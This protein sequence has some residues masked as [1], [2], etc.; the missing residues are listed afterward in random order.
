LSYAHLHLHTH[1]SLLDGANKIGDLMRRVA[2]LGMPAAAMT[3]H[4]NMFGTVEFYK[5]A[6]AHGVKPVIGC[7]VYV[8]PRSRKDRTT[9]VVSDD[10]ERG[11][12]YH[13]ILLAAD[14][15]GYRNL[16]RMVSQSYID[17]FYYKPRIDKELLR[18]F[19]EGIICLSGC[20]GSEVSSA[21][22]GDRPDVA[23]KVIEEYAS[24]F[25]D[26]YYLEMQDNHLP[27]QAKVNQF[28]REIAP[29]IGVPLVATNDC[30][31]L[32]H[33]DHEAHEV[34]LCVQTGK[35]L[36]DED[37][38]RFETDQLF[39]K[40]GDLMSAAFADCPEAIRTSL[41][42]AERC[43]VE[44][45]F[46]KSQFPVF[47]VPDER[48]LEDYL[49]SRCREGLEERLGALLAQTPDLDVETY[50]KRLESE[51]EIIIS[52]GFAGY[53][54][55]VA[56]FVN[57]AKDQ[58]VPVG[59]GRGSAAGSLVSYALKITD[60]DPI[61]YNL[62]FER[63]L[64]P[65]RVTMPDIDVD[66]CYEKRDEVVRY[67]RDKYGRDRVANIITFGT[68]K[69]KAAIRDVG[70]VLD[71]TFAETDRICK[72]YPAPKQGKDFTLAQA[73]TMEPK[74]AELRDS[75]ER[76]RKLFTYA[77]K[78]EGLARHV[79]KHAAGIVISDKPLTE[80]V[81]LFVDKDGTVMTQFAGPDIEALGLVKFDFLGL[82]TLTLIADTVRRIRE[83][84]G[85]QIDVSNLPLDDAATYRL[86]SQADTVGI[87]QM[88]SGGMQNLLTQIKPSCF[89]DLIAVLALFRPGPLDSGMV[90]TYIKRRDGREPVK[91]PDET[92]RSILSETYGVI[93]Y[94][95]QVMQIAQVYAGYTLGQADNLRRA[96]GKKKAEAMAAEKQHF[97]AGALARGHG[98]N[99]ADEI[100]QQM[101]T[102][103]AYGF[104]KSHSAAYAL[105]SF[106]TAWLKAHYP[107]EFL[108]AL[109]TMEMGDTDKVYKNLAD[110]RRHGVHVLPPDVNSSR[111]DF[112]V[113]PEGIRFGL[114]AT[115][116]VGEKAI[117]I[118]VAAREDGPFR[119]LPDFC[120]RTASDDSQVNRRIVEGLIKAGAFDTLGIERSRMMAGLEA[121]IAWA[122]RVNED[123][124]AGQ[125]GLFGAG[126]DDS[127]S[128]P[129]PEYP[130]VPPWDATIRL[131]AEHDVV[132]FYISGHPLDRYLEDIEL[133]TVTGIDRLDV[134]M[135]D[136]TVR[137]AGVINTV[138]LKNSRK[139]DRYATFNLEDRG[140]IIEVIAWP[141]AY[142]KCEAAIASREPVLVTGRVEFGE[143]RA[144]GLAAAA[145]VSEE[146]AGFA[147]SPQLIADEVV[148][149]SEARRRQARVVDL[150][151]ASGNVDESCLAKLRSTLLRHPGRCRPYLKIVRS[152]AT[153]T[154][155]ELPA[156]LAI[157]P[158]DA[159]LR[160]VE[161]VLGPG[162]AEIR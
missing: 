65:E 43:N 15:V 90:D 85:E 91:Y 83:S 125:M 112:T 21:I 37:R 1:Y 130:D 153:E 123:R 137:L 10:Y 61:R 121:A 79:S 133:L 44:L 24:L 4:G 142:R 54:L 103:A 33:E 12:N 77:S 48:P 140:G 122:G 110:A 75:G 42:I 98:R 141:E 13:L 66:F 97:M 27:Q 156:E 146:G 67:V 89:E 94:Q 148:A 56:D 22:L 86:V 162:A 147:L 120:S 16:S 106:Q 29:E 26:R 40:G 139:G 151:L 46:G 104:N 72:L 20:L 47:E 11:G 108:A 114:G 100:F 73:L 55:I 34:L 52:T 145:A 87:F 28:L 93:V 160:D 50:R 8:A 59:P 113:C 119:S 23:R 3:D 154:L 76:E 158:T 58:G 124:A 116:G 41:E 57:Y 19:H 157:D 78:L 49:K 144:A 82:K 81:P 111:A 118:I 7:E 31:Y 96:M 127:V 9:A 30:H 107:R 143:R 32:D 101:E 25:G 128:T 138:K 159:F 17:G 126:G 149:L 131:Q 71:F 14:N 136:Q 64:N 80:Y 117:E 60:I 132:G 152:G 68:L 155:I 6:V 84:T 45:T 36:A 38:W 62:L 150:K 161:D 88:E 74:L 18:E 115:K 5:A 63:F 69:G 70:R 53:F 134:R 99:A 51:I 129:E 109:L 95:E 135:A 105:V 39:V 35:R 92:L 102:F 2:R